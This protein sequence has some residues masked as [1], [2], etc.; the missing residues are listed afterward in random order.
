MPH[1]IRTREIEVGDTILTKPYNQS[2]K[3]NESYV[4]KVIKIRV[5]EQECTGQILYFDKDNQ[6]KTDYFG[7]N[8]SL[9]LHK[10]DGS[11][12]ERGLG[13]IQL[14]PENSLLSDKY[15]CQLMSNN[16]WNFANSS[17]DYSSRD[18]VADAWQNGAEWMNRIAHAN[19]TQ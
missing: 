6:V 3:E 1:D 17:S 16:S 7:A 9:L 2:N 18:I 14:V 11:K 15:L 12:L 8:D 5:S 10:G 19:L 13:N 4:G